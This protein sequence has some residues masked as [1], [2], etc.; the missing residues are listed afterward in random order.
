MYDFNVRLVTVTGKEQIASAAGIIMMVSDGASWKASV[1]DLRF[2]N[3]D[4]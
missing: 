1:L 2:N 4:T 3:T